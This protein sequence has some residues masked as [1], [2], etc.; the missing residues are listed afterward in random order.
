MGWVKDEGGREDRDPGSPVVPKP[1][2]NKTR[3]GNGGTVP[4]KSRCVEM[5][6]RVGVLSWCVALRWCVVLRW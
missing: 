4:Q 6:C 3:G 2:P 1:V 5:V